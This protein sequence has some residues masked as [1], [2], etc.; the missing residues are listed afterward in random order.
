MILCGLLSTV[1]R[2]QAKFVVRFRCPN[3]QTPLF[4]IYTEIDKDGVRIYK[5]SR[6]VAARAEDRAGDA[7]RWTKNETNEYHCATVTKRKSENKRFH[8]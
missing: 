3:A 8:S 5:K 2:R 7:R 6:L 1:G 4:D